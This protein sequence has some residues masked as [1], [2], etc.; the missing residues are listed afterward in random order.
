M[1]EA[2]FEEASL[3]ELLGRA[4]RCAGLEDALAERREQLRRW[5]AGGGEGELEPHPGAAREAREAA[6]RLSGQLR[7]LGP[8]EEA[9]RRVAGRYARLDGQERAK[10]RAR[11]AAGPEETLSRAVQE[12]RAEG[13]P[14]ELRAQLT[15]RVKAGRR[16]SEGA[17]EQLAY[18]AAQLEAAIEI[19]EDGPTGPLR[20]RVGEQLRALSG[21]ERERFAELA[22]PGQQAL[23]E[24]ARGEVARAVERP[25]GREGRGRPGRDRGISM[26]M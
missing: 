3:K 18:D 15:E 2:A 1:E 20:E 8:S 23:A 12:A 26:G 10:A 21:K 17:A 9:R 13:G 14:E 5:E 24:A 19:E 7:G 25:V 11:L 16:P 22:T 6:E 4:R